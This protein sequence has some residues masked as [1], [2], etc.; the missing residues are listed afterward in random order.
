MLSDRELARQMIERDVMNLYR[1][2]PSI[3]N[4]FGVNVSPFLGMFEDKILGYA[5]MGVETLLNMLF[6]KDPKCDI[7]EA[8][9]I[10]KMIT[11]DKIEDYRKKV[12]E[13][14][15]KEEENV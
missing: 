9:E 6:G 8:T 3:A 12:K 1:N 14:K 11:N 15:S 10:A 5:D 4:Q 7:D 13:A 2:L